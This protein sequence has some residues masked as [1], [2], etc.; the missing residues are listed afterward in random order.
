MVW[1]SVTNV[2]RLVHISQVALMQVAWIPES[3]IQ[4]YV[5]I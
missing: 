1:V 2:Q 5:H 4:A 3:R